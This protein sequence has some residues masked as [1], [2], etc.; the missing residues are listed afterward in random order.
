MSVRRTEDLDTHYYVDRYGLGS[1]AICLVVVLLSVTDA[2]LTL[3]L[4]SQGGREVNPVMDFFLRSGPLP[5][6]VAKYL[7][8]G[9]GVFWM[10][11]H[12]EYRFLGGPISG[13]HIMTS[14]LLLYF[15]LV[16]YEFSLL[17]TL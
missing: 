17:R 8:T 7:L 15:L 5:F 3:E 13:K 4:V 14:T 16:L 12:K 6:L 11:V 2:F 9:L 10:L 1:V